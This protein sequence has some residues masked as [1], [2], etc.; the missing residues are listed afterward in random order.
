MNLISNETFFSNKTDSSETNKIILITSIFN[1]TQSFIG[2]FGNLSRIFII[3]RQKIKKIKFKFYTLITL[4]FELVFCSIIF[5]DYSFQFLNK[6][7]RFLHELHQYIEVIVDFFIHS[8]DSNLSI[9]TLIYSYNR[10]KV[11]KKANERVKSLKIKK[12]NIILSIL[13][14]TVIELVNLF[15]CTT[16]TNNFKCMITYCCL[17]KQILY[18]IIPA[19]ITLIINFIFLREAFKYRQNKTRQIHRLLSSISIHRR[20]TEDDL[21]YRICKRNRDS[22][23]K[24]I[25]CSINHKPM[26]FKKSFLIFAT[27]VLEFLATVF[28]YLM[29]SLFSMSFHHPFNKYLNFE[30]IVQTQA[31]STIIFI[32]KHLLSIF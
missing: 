29:I 12:I 4:I 26:N 30:L 8:I 1:L 31:I 14:V 11:I 17:L 5:M 2:I 18:S 10:L 20:P 32:L 13:I 24:L 23:L 19:I 9:L 6:K 7:K 15:V 25:T 3:I 22:K 27:S 28:Y 16:L 21:N